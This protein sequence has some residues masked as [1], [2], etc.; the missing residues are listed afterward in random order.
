MYRLFEEIKIKDK[1]LFYIYGKG[2][3]KFEKIASHTGKDIITNTES[4]F[5]YNDIV[6]VVNE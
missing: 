1:F 5:N 2:E 4:Y 6:E 3:V